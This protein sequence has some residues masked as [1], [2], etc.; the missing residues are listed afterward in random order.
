V[1]VLLVIIYVCLYFDNNFFV[2]YVKLLEFQWGTAW[3][4]KF[5]FYFY[6][7]LTTFKQVEDYVRA[8]I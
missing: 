6:Q 2:F 4:V 3:N 1:N 8:C 7:I 5:F